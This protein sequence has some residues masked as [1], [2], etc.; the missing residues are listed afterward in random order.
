MEFYHKYPIQIRFNDIDLLSHVT[1]SVYQQYFDLGRMYYFK[2]VLQEQL[3][4]KKEGLILV[5]IHINFIS[6]VQLNDEVEVRTKVVKLGNKSL[7]MSQ[8]V[9]NHST[10][11]V[12]AESTSIMV[13]YDIPRAES[14]PLLQRWRDKIEN[15]ETDIF[16]KVTGR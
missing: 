4:W 9:F 3:D 13:G 6:Q 5:S 11:S 15:F 8:Q 7:E 2:E 12:A 16:S 10:N 14:M 1:N